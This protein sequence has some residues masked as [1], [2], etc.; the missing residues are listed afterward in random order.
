VIDHLD[1]D[2]GVM[3]KHWKL[4]EDKEPIALYKILLR[5]DNHHHTP[6]L[7]VECV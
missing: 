1:F 4:Q 5:K 6:T 3:R 7:L 2:M